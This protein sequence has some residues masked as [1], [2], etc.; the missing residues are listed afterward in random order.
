MNKF[1][2]IAALAVL[3]SCGGDPAPT[4]SVEDAEAKAT[5][6]DDIGRLRAQTF[7]QEVRMDRAVG[8]DLMKTYIAF[9]NSYP[10]DSLTA[11]YL[12]QAASIGQA[13]GKY[14]KSIELLSNVHDG[15]PTFNKRVESLF[16]IAFTYQRDMN[17]RIM[18]EKY[19]Q[20][21]IENYPESIWAE[22]AQASLAT[23]NLTD[24]QLLDFLEEQNAGEAT[25]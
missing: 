6:R 17:D 8:H 9:A 16:L 21:V 5:M 22:Q 23:L 15:Y 12:F 3:T 10:Q 1:F 4:P 19:Y 20:Q 14:R 18:A 24:D 7:E 11:E 2:L 13:L 25:R